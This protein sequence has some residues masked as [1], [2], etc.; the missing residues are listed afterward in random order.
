MTD[1]FEA[2]DMVGD[3]QVRHRDKRVSRGIAAL[4]GMWAPLCWGLAAF[5]GLTNATASQPAPEAALPFIVGGLAALGVAMGV[6]AVGFA[7]LRTVV[8][9]TEVNVKYGL[10]GPNIPLS[11][12]QSC[13]V[14]DYQWTRFGGWGIRRGWGGKW[15]Y[16][17]GPGE[18]VEIQYDDGG[19]K[20]TVLIGAKDPHKLMLEIHKAREALSK[21]PIAV[22]VS[23]ADNDAEEEVVSV[24]ED[25]VSQSA[26]QTKSL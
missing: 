9:D 19:S 12:I 17:P 3:A 22:Y 21:Q 26:G 7:V 8:T 10:W 1:R 14:V 2:E 5:T 15:A 25:A 24:E 6:M 11:S 20:K 4:L 16:V 13:K 23:E 18:A